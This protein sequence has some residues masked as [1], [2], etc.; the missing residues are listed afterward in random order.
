MARQFKAEARY[1]RL[2]ELQ[3]L[4]AQQQLLSIEMHKELEGLR[5]KGD[6]YDADL[7]SADHTA[8]KQGHN[9]A[10]A[11]LGRHSF[12]HET[13]TTATTRPVFYLDGSNGGTSQAL[14]EAGYDKDT[15]L[16]VANEW[17]DTTLAL[18][19]PPLEL[20]NIYGGSAATALATTFRDVPFGAAYLDGCGGATP[21]VIDMIE[22]LLSAPRHPAGLVVGFTLTAAEPSGRELLDRIGDV[23]RATLQL[24]G[25]QHY[26]HMVHVLDDPERFG[27][28]PTLSRKHQGTATC[29][30]ALT[31]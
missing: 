11:I 12:G 6:P 22:S 27:I 19:G 10:F 16:F 17:T 24:L 31:P 8:F 20:P 7:F 28:D 13:T 18:Q 29:W 14:L 30:L 26:R 3:D 23:T 15:E 25:T 9:R 2:Q 21:P 1:R 5:S 4:S